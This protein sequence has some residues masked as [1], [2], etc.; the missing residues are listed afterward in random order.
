MDD[1][2]R[3]QPEEKTEASD[4]PEGLTET[5][6]A[7]VEPKEEGLQGRIAE[8]EG[9]LAKV[10]SEAKDYKERWLRVL[11][12]YQNYRKRVMQ[13]RVE[14]YN[15]GKRRAVLE[16]L[17]V[18]DNLERALMTLREGAD[19]TA[20]R[21][22]LDLIVQLF[23]EALRHLDIE[24]IPTEGHRFDPYWHEAFER[25]E[26]EDLEEGMIVGE[27][28]RGYRM[29]DQVLR[30]AKVRVAVKPRPQL[31]PPEREGKGGEQGEPERGQG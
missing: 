6:I 30:P 15:E 9:Q 3:Q 24:V 23:R 1:Q 19:L 20:Y 14:A 29:G 16:L 17:P 13:E 27:V 21:K 25:V 12:E 26:C 31:A 10:Q 11:A 8:L 4:H 18:L 2:K 22:G 7:G 5:P 28:E